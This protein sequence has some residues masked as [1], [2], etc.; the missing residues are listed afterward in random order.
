MIP[1]P[2]ACVEPVRV[3]KAVIGP[4]RPLALIAGPCVIESEKAAL[5]AA[6]GILKAAEKAGVPL[7]YKS[8]FE[9]DNRSSHTGYRG[10]GR[11][12]GLNILAK[13]KKTFGLPVLSDIHREEDLAEAA[14]VLDVIQIPAFL[15]QQTSLLLAAGRAGRTVNVKKG[16]F[17]APESMKGT[18]EKLR[19]AGAQQVLLTERGTTFG[20]HRLVSDMRAIPI[21]QDLGCPVVFDAGHSVRYY[22]VT[23]SDPK[24]GERE[25]IPTLARAGIAAGADALFLES[26]PHPAKA[27]CD[28]VTQFPIK[29][30]V[31]LLRQLV[32]IRQTISEFSTQHSTLGTSRKAVR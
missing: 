13:V 4:G 24:G 17:M 8:S 27:M 9:K 11:V 16:Q 20:Y 3:G 18:V 23:S 10:P 19:R 6:E 2:M 15:C 29:E 14:T 1:P 12:K 28:A 25:F 31:P 7:I 21:M 30:L 22:G 5:T 26:H 32:Q